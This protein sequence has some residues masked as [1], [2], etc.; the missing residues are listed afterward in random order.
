MTDINKKVDIGRKCQ[1]QLDHESISD[2]HCSV[3]LEDGSL[4]LIDH[5]NLTGTHF[6]DSEEEIE[7]FSEIELSDG[8]VFVL[9]KSEIQIKVSKI[10]IVPAF[11]LVS[12]SHFIIV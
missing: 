8:D 3:F 9:G 4:F 5:G 11:S 6:L 1:F 12:N 7:A 2:C 10:N